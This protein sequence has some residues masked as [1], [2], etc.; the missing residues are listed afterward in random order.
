MTG[1]HDER[2]A[3]LELHVPSQLHLYYRFSSNAQH[4]TVE[5]QISGILCLPLNSFQYM[6]YL[7][8]LL[9]LIKLFFRTKLR[10]SFFITI[11]SSAI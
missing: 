6:F 4:S 9:S 5:F 11:F 2:L 10:H 8:I 7:F 1:R 3:E